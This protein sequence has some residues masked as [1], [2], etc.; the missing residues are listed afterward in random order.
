M[1]RRSPVITP[2]DL[3]SEKKKLKTLEDSRAI[4]ENMK[5][6][7]DSMATDKNPEKRRRVNLDTCLLSLRKVVDFQ[8]TVVDYLKDEIAKQGAPRPK[9]NRGDSNKV[10]SKLGKTRQK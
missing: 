8:R 7:L 6:I 3:K 5:E 4:L 10:K 1:A 9:A 2:E